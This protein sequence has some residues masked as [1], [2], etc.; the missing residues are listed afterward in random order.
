MKLEIHDA[1]KAEIL[2]QLEWYDQ[3]DPR[4][5]DRLAGLFEAAAVAIA[6][7]PLSFP[8]VEIE[9]NPGDIRRV[10]LKGFP[11]YVLYQVLPNEARI[12]A[13]QHASRLPGYWMSR[14]SR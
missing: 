14:L 2:A 10:R 4:V 13:V 9:G 12:F 5:G 1:A 11:I 8:L 6:R 7:N 3:R